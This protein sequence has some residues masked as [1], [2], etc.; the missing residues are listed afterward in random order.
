MNILFYQMG[1][2]PVGGGVERVT[3]NISRELCRRNINIYVAYWNKESDDGQN[4]DGI[5]KGII[6]QPLIDKQAI[7]RLKDFILSHDIEIIVNQRAENVRI[8]K[9]LYKLKLQCHIK[10]YSFLHL[11]PTAS[12]DGSH[13]TDYR[14]PSLIV[15][16]ILKRILLC[17]FQYDRYRLTYAYNCSDKIVLLSER[18]KKD[19][20]SLLDMKFV[21][22]HKLCFIPNSC[23]FDE[24]YNPNC[25]KDKR[26][27]ILVVC[28]MVENNKRVLFS[29]DLWRR[30]YLDYPDWQMVI[31]GDGRDL[32]KYKMFAKM[33]GLKNLV[34]TGKIDPLPFYR[35]ASVFLMTSRFE[36]FGMT[37]LESQQMGVVPIAIDTYKSLHDIVQDNYNGVIVKNEDLDEMDRCVRRVL[38]DEDLRTKIAYNEINSSKRFKPSVIIESWM[39]LLNS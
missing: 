20:I 5:Y 24:F 34:F 36:G 21:D 31:I 23:S 4:Y 26:K 17:L 15:R 11:C 10:L 28:R 3:F 35:E 18:F 12:R 6:C 2:S 7:K 38:D 19:F 32:D 25:L 22:E 30:I 13:Y 1:L 33:Y 8:T 37:L 27:I 16:S 29:I 9:K 39:A 14:F